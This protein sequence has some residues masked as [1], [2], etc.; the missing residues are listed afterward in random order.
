M[1][2]T[3]DKHS[4]SGLVALDDIVS[5]FVLGTLH[6]LPGPDCHIGFRRLLTGVLGV[7]A[8]L[9]TGVLRVFAWVFT[10]ILRVL[11]RIFARI[12]RL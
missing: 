12:T 7:F 10:G 6:Q 8:W 3:G 11:A 4:R 9:L 1:D 5:G 2:S